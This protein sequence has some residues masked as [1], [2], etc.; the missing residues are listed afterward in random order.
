MHPITDREGNAEVV[1]YQDQTHMAAL[2]CLAEQVEDLSLR[3]DVESGRG[4]V[5]DQELR[6]PRERG[7]Q[8]DSLCHPARDLKWISCPT[9]ALIPTSPSRRVGLGAPRPP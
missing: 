4:L 5:R 3:G 7:G 8:S 9:S 2:L 1:G 6:I